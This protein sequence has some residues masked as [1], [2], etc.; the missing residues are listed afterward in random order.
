MFILLAILAVVALLSVVWLR[1]PVR[2]YQ[3]RNL[4]HR[5]RGWKQELWAWLG[6]GNDSALSATVL[7]ADGRIE[8]L[9]IVSRR[10]VTNDGVAFIVDAFQNLVELEAMNAHGM[11]TGTNA[12]NATDA[13]LQ[14]EVETRQSGTQTEP[15]NNQ[16]RTTATLTA[17]ASRAITEHGLFNSTTVGGSKLFDR[18]VFSAINLANGDSIQFQYTLTV[19][20][21]G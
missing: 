1:D 2:R 5:V 21:G 7:R 13:A 9:G 18:S 19:S 15:A 10:V 16:Y 12:E 17:T 20:A 14:T 3:V 6:V 4:P 8:R 11:G